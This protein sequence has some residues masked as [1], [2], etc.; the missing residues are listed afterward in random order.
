MQLDFWLNKWQKK[1]IGF[2]QDAVNPSLM[3]YWPRLDVGNQGRVLVPLC[4]KTQDMLWLAGQGHHVVGVEI[5]PIA[6]QEFFAENQLDA[7]HAQLDGLDHWSAGAVRLICGDFFATTAAV[8]DEVMAVYDRAALIALPPEL[9]RRYVA[10]LSSLLPY[11]TDILLVVIDY[12]PAEMDGPPFSVNDHEVNALYGAEFS[13][14]MLAERDV[15][16]ENPRFRQRGLTRMI[17]RVYRLT[18][19]A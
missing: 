18:K 19:L 14:S 12:P 15:L 4:G 9:R 3:D 16:D 8:V 10:H 17:E 13:I 2:H 1:D 7:T 11:G 6:V 5:S